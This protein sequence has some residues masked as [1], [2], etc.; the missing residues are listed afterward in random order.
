MKRPSPRSKGLRGLLK[1]LDA[2]LEECEAILV[3]AR[4]SLV[5]AMDQESHQKM[6][7]NLDHICSHQGRGA[8]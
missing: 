1:G 8:T 2:D 6:V 7:E 3:E 5:K 4:K